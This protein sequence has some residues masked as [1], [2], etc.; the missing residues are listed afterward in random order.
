MSPEDI[1]HFLIT[2]D[3]ATETTTIEEFGTDY[4]AALAAYGKAERADWGGRLDIVLI[5]SDSLATIEKTHSSYF[6]SAS[7]LLAARR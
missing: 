7:E 2:L 4:D 1:K 5:S 6:K 3:P